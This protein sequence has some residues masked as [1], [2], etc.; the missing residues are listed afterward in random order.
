MHSALE[1]LAAPLLLVAPFALGFGIFAGFVS[2]ALGALLIGLAVSAYGGQGERGTLPLTAH[3]G[4]DRVLA[5]DADRHRNRRRPLLR[6]HP[7]NDLHGRFRLRAPG[8]DRL[9]A[10][11]PPA[12]SLTGSPHTDKKQHTYLSSL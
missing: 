6:R 3:A 1:M 4:F 10:V 2:F 9:N 5:G 11:Q 12:R 7:R 8:A